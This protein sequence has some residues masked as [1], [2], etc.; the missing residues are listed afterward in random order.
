[1]MTGRRSPVAF[2]SEHRQ[3]P[4]LREIDPDPIVE[5]H[6]ETARSLGIEDGNWV[7]IEGRRGRAKRKAKLTPIVHPKMV[8]APHGWW[9]PEKEGED[10][11]YGV[12]DI[13]VNQLIP[14]GYQ[15]KSG[16]GGGP[17]K[18]MLCKIYKA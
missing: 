5:I 14:M 2:H 4:W 16:F 13:N 11:L 7:W 17:Y 18:S 1:M 6:P 3:I 10:H 9:Y 8:M 15:S 12:W